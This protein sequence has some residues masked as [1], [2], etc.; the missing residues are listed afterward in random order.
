MT[1]DE[2]PILIR[3]AEN[4]RQID[5]PENAKYVIIE[6]KEEKE[7]LEWLRDKGKYS[8]IGLRTKLNGMREYKEWRETRQ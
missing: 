6:T 7:Y 2:E 5:D 4:T 8:F 3:K 1:E